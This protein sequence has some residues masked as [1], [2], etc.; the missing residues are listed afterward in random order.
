[1]RTSSASAASTVVSPD[2]LFETRA[3]GLQAGG[4]NVA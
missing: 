4:I 1:M 3:C 2:P